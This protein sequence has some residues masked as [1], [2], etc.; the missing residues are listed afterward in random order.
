LV[1]LAR[2][3]E[4][5]SALGRAGRARAQAVFDLYRN[6]AEL[7]RLCAEAAERA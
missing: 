4:R 6:I 7:D 3:P 2:Q 5:C 1:E